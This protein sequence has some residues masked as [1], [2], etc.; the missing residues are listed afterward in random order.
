V[1]GGG[2]IGGY[3]KA[4]G[5]TDF[6]FGS[7]SAVA[8]G[9]SG[10]SGGNGQQ[11]GVQNSGSITTVEVNSA[12]ILAQSIGGGGGAGGGA[13]AFAAAIAGDAVAFSHGGSGGGG[14]VGGN[15][16][17]NCSSNCANPAPLAA[18][19]PNALISTTG[20]ASPGL[21]AQS[22]GGGGGA[23]GYAV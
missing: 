1:G 21:A 15:V 19:S 7:S 9:G 18:A 20:L 13:L 11:V 16:A 12:G 3:A 22:I 5:H 4:K 6:I 8:L 2:G 14:G 17:I 23:G 10:G